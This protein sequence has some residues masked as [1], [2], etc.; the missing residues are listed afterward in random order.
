MT[1]KY[2][3]YY[4]VAAI[5]SGAVLAP[6]ASAQDIQAESAT[7]D[8][9]VAGEPIVVT[10][11]RR[12][13]AIQDVGLSLSVL[14][15]EQLANE[16]IVEIADVAATLPGFDLARGN[17]SNNPTMTVRGVGTTNPWINNN[18]S[19]AAYVDDAYMP[20]S[21]FLSFPI[22][23]IER[24]EL[25][26]GPQVALYGRNATAGALNIITARPKSQFGGYV[27][28][29]YNEHDL[30]EARGAVTGP[31]SP[32][33]NV[34]LAGIV[35]QG[36]G[37]IDRPGT[38]NT[39]AG[40]SPVPGVV[41]GVPLVPARE[42]YG[43]K[44]I[45]AVR[46]SAEWF[47]SDQVEVFVTGHY[48]RDKSQIIGSTAVTPDRLRRFTPPATR[49]PFVDYDNA[50]PRMDSEQYGGVFRVDVDLAAFKLTSVT[51]YEHI[52]RSFT[53]GDFV[54]TRIAEPVFDE[55]ISAFNQE[56]RLTHEGADTFLMVGASYGKETIDYRRDL[57]AY[58]LL[59]GTLS[60][61]FTEKDRSFAVFGQAE[62]EFAPEL[63]LIGGLRHTTEDKSYS[64]GS[65]ELDP[66]GVSIVK[67]VY[68]NTAGDGLF[69]NP[70]YH[71]TDISGSLALN[72][73]PSREVLVYASA[74]KGF[75]SGGF[76]GSGITEP[77]SFTPY[78]AENIR[79][80]E[81]GA[82]FF[83][84]PIQLSGAFFYYDYTDKQVL[85]LVDLGSGITEAIIQNAA[86]STIYGMDLDLSI[87]LSDALRFSLNGLIV[88]SEVTDWQSVDP[89][90]VAS[91][92]G[93]E[94]PG[95]P[96]ASLNARLD[97][98][99]DISNDW[100]LEL[101]TWTSYSDGAYRDIENTRN[102]RSDDR[103][104]A[105]AR[106]ELG[107]IDGGPQFY[108]LGKNLFNETYVT[109][110]RSLVGMLGEYYGEPR[111]ITAGIRYDF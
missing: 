6:N 88:S 18:P 36:G 79:A 39:T 4:S 71:D 56:L 102:L 28:V 105:N 83:G 46:G 76:D 47:A 97:W 27:D 58:D 104:L 44:D 57:L 26:K 14:G 95:T 86:G 5:L 24:V 10:A 92:I 54:P 61:E 98:S 19:V 21:P 31:I 3:L 53:I 110:V 78:G 33:A 89:A 29:S 64:G 15:S 16:K 101:S 109:S 103:F 12:E 38:A 96:Q 75:K 41:P 69:G 50:E 11:Q 81:L 17:G 99:H 7:T 37:Y 100:Q 22:F 59:R 32:D 73:K 106:I 9:D 91:R 49:R 60:T 52:D 43:D 77:S 72:W 90:E 67:A 25:L 94:L 108:L 1:R 40:F 42:G 30:I 48:G 62:W 87:R 65:I 66:F 74:S 107:R 82:K 111:T 55:N 35:A 80:Y 63:T 2:A 51:G 68:P 13:Q 8:A 84:D 93:N 45:Y 70:E 23:D 34:R 20:F 85:A